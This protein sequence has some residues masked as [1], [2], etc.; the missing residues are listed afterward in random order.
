MST[1]TRKKH[2]LAQAQQAQLDLF[3]VNLVRNLNEVFDRPYF[4]DSRGTMD[5]DGVIDSCRAAVRWWEG[6]KADVEGTLARENNGES[7]D[8][9]GHDGVDLDTAGL[10]AD[11]AQPDE[12]EESCDKC[13]HGG[14]DLDTAGLCADCAQPD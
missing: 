12:D 11:C 7:C 1:P 14:V 4:E 6:F 5:R 13:G 10:C 3:K 9:C 8:E 2:K